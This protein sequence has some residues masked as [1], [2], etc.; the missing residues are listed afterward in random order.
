MIGIVAPAG[1]YAAALAELPLSAHRV[2][3]PDGS[4]VVVPGTDG[5]VDAALAAVS[6]GAVAL[7]IADPA[8]VPAADLRRLAE[9]GI[10]IIIERALLRADVTADAVAARTAASGA[11]SPRVLVAEATASRAEL[12]VAV[13]DAVGWLRILGGDRLV[14]VTAH[15]GLALLETS[16]GIAATLTVV[17]NRRP[18]GGRI[19]AQALGETIT[20]VEVEG[21]YV[22]VTTSSSVGRLI[23]PTRFESSE[24]LALRRAAGVLT[25]LT[26]PLDLA[27][28]LVDTE[29]AA[30]IL[31]APA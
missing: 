29:V 24:R 2:D 27:E 11:V 28:L 16:A 20:E 7:L 6:A 13:R 1:P 25:S 31:N 8:F 14:L 10:P 21:R 4:I 22:G 12:S 5:W 30:L 26:R 15:E 9:V 3:R 18:G 17:A 23:A 19:T